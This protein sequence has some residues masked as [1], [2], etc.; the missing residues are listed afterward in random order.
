[1]LKKSIFAILLVILFVTVALSACDIIS[2]NPDRVNALS[3]EEAVKELGT[4]LRTIKVENRPASLDI[5]A[6][7]R[8]E[9]VALADISVF[10][11]STLG[12]ADIVIEAAVDT[13]MS[14]TYFPDDWANIVAKKFNE[15]RLTINGKTVAVSIRTITAGETLTYQTEAGYRPDMFIPSSYLFGQMLD[16][17]GIE[18][19]KIAEKVAGNVA[20]ILMAKKTYDNFITEYKEVN[21]ANVLAANGKDLNGR[22]FT[23]TYTNPFTS[24]TGFNGVCSI[25]DVYDHDNPLSATA[26]EKLEAYQRQ[27]P[28]V[29]YTTAVLRDK[30]ADGIIDAMVMEY[31]AWFGKKDQLKDFAFIPF[32]VRHDHPVYTYNYVSGEKQEAVRLFTE[33][34]L[35]PENQ[36]LATDRGFNPAE[37]ESYSGKTY[38]LDG[39]G[40]LA[41]QQVW[42]QSKDGGRPI[43]AV[44]VADI[45]GSM[46]GL[47]LNSLKE[48]LINTSK[49]IGPNNH[50]GL[51]SFSSNVNLNLEIGEF[52]N[53]QR[54][55][56]SGAVKSLSAGGGT[57]TYNAVLVGLDLLLKKKEE[58]PDA[59]LMLFVLSDGKQNEGYNLKRVTPIVGGLQI[60]IY[61]IGYNL[62]ND[63][64]AEGELQRLS[65]INEAIL[66]NATSEDLINQLRNLFNIQM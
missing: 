3:Y 24:S 47:P 38:N 36:K 25:L 6:S 32:G 30:A 64:S 13:E 59:K 35:K 27:S 26:R 15:Q 43:V 31:Q 16:A 37:H 42:K 10:P 66:I 56:F 4:F 60:P 44:F 53:T 48:S 17:S 19:I 57:A 9:G 45:S 18:T 55:Y 34:L 7:D 20:G 50:I 51:V 11:L 23:F 52:D 63:S 54:A 39:A 40:L 33:Y 14:E 46:D 58:V 49:F 22:V 5:Y 41:A 1:M 2:N 65:L 12:K 28:P 21:M 29:G 62:G 61:S 8:F